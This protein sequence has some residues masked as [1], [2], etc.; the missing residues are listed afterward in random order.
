MEIQN[1]KVDF[2]TLGFTEKQ[3]YEFPKIVNLEVYR[4]DCPCSCVHCPVGITKPNKRKERFDQKVIDLRLYRKIV[5]EMSFYPLSTLRIHS[6]GEPLIWEDLL[7]ALEYSHHKG[8]RSWIFTCALT[9]KKQLLNMVCQNTSIVE[10][11]L[12]STTPEDYKT[13]KG[14]DAF[15]LV[16]ENIK[17]IHDL[18]RKG[19][20]VR[21]IVSRVQS[22]NRDAD[23]EFIRYWRSTGLVDDAFVRTYHTYNDL[24]PEVSNKCRIE[25]EACLVHWARFN[26]SV[27]GY[28]V[29]CFNELFKEKLEHSLI[30]GDLNKE[31]ISSIWHGSSL[32]ALRHAELTGDYS[33]LDF[34]DVLPCK[35][36]RSFQPLK[37]NRQT[38]EYQIKQI[39]KGRKEIC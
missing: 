11:S 9:D 16:V 28:A 23:N 3:M 13:T 22:L 35:D 24:M 18:K 15:N 10:V 6:V 17:Y 26:I 25:H 8:I 1:A 32:S 14:I 36:C 27:D 31:S 2:R 38:S 37:G 4:G 12:N 20:S 29:V 7:K 34:T 33:K 30:L 21:L 19:S 39:E 5:E